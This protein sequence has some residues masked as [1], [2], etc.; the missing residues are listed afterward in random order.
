VEA[1]AAHRRQQ[2]GVSGNLQFLSIFQD[3]SSYQVTCAD[4]NYTFPTNTLIP[5]GAFFVLAA[6][7]QGIANVYGLTP[8]SLARTPAA[9]N[10]PR[11]SNCWMNKAMYC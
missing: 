11:P 8:M 10:I 2:R 4:M 5:G 1:R 6:S 9:S 7:P 3:I